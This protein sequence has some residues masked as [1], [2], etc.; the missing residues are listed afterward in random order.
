MSHSEPRFDASEQLTVGVVQL[1]SEPSVEANL[2][3]VDD[4]ARDAARRGARFVVL[5]E[6]FALMAD[7]EAKRGV[8]EKV[9]L[10]PIEGAGPILLRLRAIAVR[11]S[12]WLVAGGMPEAS[13]DPERPYNSCVVV[14]PSG[15]V[16]AR[17]RKIHL[18][19]VDVG[20][21]QS[22]R[23]SRSTMAGDRACVVDVERVRVGL[24]ICY[25]LR[26]PALYR[27]LVA[28]GAVVLV[29]PA[30]FTLLTG[31]DHWH[32]LLRARAIESQSYVLAAAQWGVHAG[33][34]RTYGK[35]CIVDPW[36]DVVAQA[37]EGEGVTVATI[38]L[39][40]VARVRRSLPSLEHVRPFEPPLG[41]EDAAR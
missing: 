22:Y 3:R 6:N 7:E 8:A 33:G 10:G 31:K 32:A 41:S 29:V 11:E 25:D 35:S 23:E 26:F 18:F 27:S 39:G 20:D 30:A 5:P 36:G 12:M 1:Q 24:S 2:D 40:R 15:E 28:A 17:Y 19:D 37:S 34:R 14:A 13:A 16:V 38:D 4:L 21:G 9:A